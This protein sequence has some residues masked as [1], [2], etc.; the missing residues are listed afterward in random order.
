LENIDPTR[1]GVNVDKSSGATI[2]ELKLWVT[3]IPRTSSPS[4]G[5]VSR[6]AKDPITLAER[7]RA[8]LSLTS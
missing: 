4:A 8:N 6:S 5:S 7:R 1:S 2:F 3:I